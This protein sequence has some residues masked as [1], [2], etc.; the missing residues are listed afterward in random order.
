MVNQL[1]YHPYLTQPSLI[2]FCKDNKIQPEA[3]SPLMQGHI[4]EVKLLSDIGN[5]YGKSPV[6]VVLRW[7]LQNGVITL[8][9]SVRPDRIKE[10]ADIFDFELTEDEMNDINNLNQGF[11]FGS[12]PDN[13][14]F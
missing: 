9:K 5:K 11:R 12:D 2:K 7:D 14:N 8:P 13:F 10:N 3:W 6:Q 1:E 4:T